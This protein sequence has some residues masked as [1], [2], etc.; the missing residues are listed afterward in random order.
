M[1]ALIALQPWVAAAFVTGILFPPIGVP[2]QVVTAIKLISGL[3]KADRTTLIALSCV[4]WLGL[5]ALKRLNGEFANRLQ[6]LRAPQDPL[7]AKERKRY[8][9]LLQA[10]RVLGGGIT[11]SIL[12]FNLALKANA[13]IAALLLVTVALV[14]AWAVCHRLLVP[15]R[16]RLRE[17][18]YVDIFATDASRSAYEEQVAEH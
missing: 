18:G 12:A 9:I 16:N 11:L 5:I 15:L 6:A 13:N 4:P 10:R 7:S 2:L 17:A 8:R 1:Q 3:A 14:A